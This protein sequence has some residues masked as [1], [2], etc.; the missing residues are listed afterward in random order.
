M[1]AST[2][3]VDAYAPHGPY[4]SPCSH[5]S[6]STHANV[7]RRRRPRASASSED[8]YVRTHRRTRVREDHPERKRQSG[9]KAG[10][11]GGDLRSRCWPAQRSQV[12]RLLCLGTSRWG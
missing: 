7:T 4:V 6:T 3:F 2:S 10:G 12:D 5:A 8:V 1:T 9:R 11:R